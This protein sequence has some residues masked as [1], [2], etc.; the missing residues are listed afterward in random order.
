MKFKFHI[1]PQEHP[2]IRYQHETVALCEGLQEL[3]LEFFGSDNYWYE[4]EKN[5]Y[6]VKKA[7]PDYNSDVDVYS[8]FYFR[9][10][11]EAINFVNYNKIN[12][13][14][15]REDGLYGEYGNPKYKRFNLILRTHYNKNINYAYYNKK[16]K[17]WAF[18]LTNRIIQAVDQ[19]EKEPILDRI[20]MSFR[21]THDLRSR[22]VNEMSPVISAK[23]PIFEEITM[24]LKNY[25][26]T[27]A[28]D[29]DR[30]NWLQSGHRH[31]PKY[32]RLLNTSR[33]TYAFGGFI[34]P[35]PFATNRIVRQLQVLS[36]AKANILKRFGKDNSKCYMIDQFD[37]W[38]LWESFYSS[39]CPI[40]MDF[41][42][43]GWVLPVMPKSKI[44]YWGVEG[45]RFKE[46]AEELLAV[47]KESLE[48]ITMEGRKWS[49]ENYSPIATAKRF[50]EMIKML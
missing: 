8:T 7:S 2:L 41:E 1:V 12:V 39:T 16:I 42:Y 47:K 35:K 20:F 37:S 26:P 50:V 22:A 31:D 25:D 17:P 4:N 43:W 15:D 18:G 14:I 48:Q 3:G 5:G 36:G 40:H 23:F 13:F 27:F 46:A 32:F 9:A 45:F 30:L 24:S 49:A 38:R 28:S 33:L 10:F 44:H 21:L 6:L 29:T 34:Y 19:Q 11:P